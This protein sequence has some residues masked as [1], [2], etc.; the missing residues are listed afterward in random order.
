VNWRPITSC[1]EGVRV[2]TRLIDG[3]NAQGAYGVRNEQRLTKRGRLFFADDGMYVYYTPS[4]W[5]EL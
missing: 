2:H 4:E 1:P 5:A 3:Y